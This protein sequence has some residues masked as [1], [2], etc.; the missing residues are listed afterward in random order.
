MNK[1][2]IKKWTNN[3]HKNK[4]QHGVYSNMLLLS[5]FLF[6]KKKKKENYIIQ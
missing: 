3:I 6:F 4:K 5:K 2:Y 1:K